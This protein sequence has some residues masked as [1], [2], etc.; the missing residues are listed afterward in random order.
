MLQ[1]LIG[2]VF[3]DA[4]SSPLEPPVPPLKLEITERGV[5]VECIWI[6]KTTVAVIA[7]FIGDLNVKF[8]LFV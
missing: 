3:D 7:I 8:Q 5:A 1:F 6:N 4:V 2:N